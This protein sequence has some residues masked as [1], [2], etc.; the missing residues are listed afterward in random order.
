MVRLDARLPRH[1]ESSTHLS[2]SAVT[3]S[4]PVRSSNAIN[5]GL[6]VLL[7]LLSLSCFLLP[8][9][10]SPCF[11][12]S[13]L[14]RILVFPPL[15]HFC[16]IYIILAYL[17]TPFSFSCRFPLLYSLFSVVLHVL[18]LMCYSSYS[19]SLQLLLKSGCL[20]ASM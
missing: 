10:H 7:Q 16:L 12:S 19:P 6:P 5:L 17:P 11:P 3:V 18:F 8:F 20:S 13:L 9:T 15:E 14:I 2:G 1:L 4:W